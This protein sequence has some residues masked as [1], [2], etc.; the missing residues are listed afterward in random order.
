MTFHLLRD[1]TCRPGLR[2]FRGLAAAVGIGIALAGCSVHDLITVPPP[3]G[4]SDSDQLKTYTGAISMADGAQ[5]LFNATF[6]GAYGPTLNQLPSTG[7]YAVSTGVLGD[8]FT[9]WSPDPLDQ[10]LIDFSNPG[11]SVGLF[12]F[13]SSSHLNAGQA[14]QYLHTYASAAPTYYLA[15]MYLVRAFSAI[16]LSEFYC[17]GVPLAD[18]STDGRV[19]YT[20]AVSRDSLWAT[21]LQD[22]DSATVYVPSDSVSMAT[23]I[24]MAQA[25]VYLNQKQLD[26]AAQTVADVPTS[27]S[28]TIQYSSAQQV[29]T[30][31][32]QTQVFVTVANNK[33]VNGLNYLTA[34][35]PRIPSMDL[36]GSFNGINVN[37]PHPLH[38]S[39]S[40]AV[41]ENGIDARLIEA[42]AALA[43]NDVTTW[44]NILNTLR[45]TAITPAM[46][47]LSVDS[48]TNAPDSL[49]LRVM[50]R[51]RAFW[52]F[53]TGHREADMRRLVRQYNLPQSSVFPVGSLSGPQSSG[54]QYGTFT[55]AVPGP[56]EIQ[57]NPAYTGC[58]DRNA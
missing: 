8:E 4:V 38:L 18:A 37:V 41:L 35:D 21:A 56:T 26:K 32:F 57:N 14:I 40:S 13:I 19:T 16:F 5:A 55:N 9:V 12:T 34:H 49:R 15:R 33:G 27:F 11:S 22:L 51:E 50:F 17:N 30:G 20:G 28:Y 54:L 29:S 46:P 23:L 43:D 47:P 48:T 2:S 24:K 58:I 6:M 31:W 10:R 44:A 52:L 45:Q 7:P 3:S 39:P 36:V 53:G 1:M 25:R 42:E